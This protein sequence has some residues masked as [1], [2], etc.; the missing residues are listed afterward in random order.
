MKD[1]LVNNNSGKSKW[2]SDVIGD[3]FKEW[4]FKKDN[5]NALGTDASLVYIEAPTGSG[6]TYFILKKLL[7]YAIEKG[8]SIL[9]LSNRNILLKQIREEV[10]S[11]LHKKN[12]ENE[13]DDLLENGIFMYSTGPS[14][15]TVINYQS[16][17]GKVKAGYIPPEFLIEHYYVI[18]DEVHFFLEDSLFN[19]YIF[20]CFDLLMKT[21]HAS[22][23]VFISATIE[24]TMEVIN[25]DILEAYIP[26]RNNI[27]HLTS[28]KSIFYYKINPSIAK[29]KPYYFIEDE[30]II[31]AI[32]Q[33]R[34]DDKWLIFVSSKKHGIKLEAKITSVI[35]ELISDT[36]KQLRVHRTKLRQLHNEERA[37]K[38]EQI[39][40]LESEL[41]RL[42]KSTVEFIC[43]EDKGNLTT[44][45]IEYNSRFSRKVLIAT[46]VLD[47]GVNIKDSEVKHIVLP[48]SHRV[49]FIQMLGRKRLKD[50]E[51]VKLYIQYFKESVIASRNEKYRKMYAVCSKVDDIC[52]SLDFLHHPDYEIPR[53]IKREIYHDENARMTKMIQM[54]WNEEKPIQNL[55]YIDNARNLKFN[56]FA[57]SQLVNMKNFY[58]NL[59]INYKSIGEQTISNL[60]LDWLGPQLISQPQSLQEYLYGSLDEFIKKN[61]YKPIPLE[62]QD[63]FYNNY[64]RIFNIWLQHQY[65]TAPEKSEKWFKI[66]KGKD[67][68]KA[69]I[70]KSLKI[71]EKPYKLI[72]QNACWMLVDINE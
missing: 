21:Y 24:E 30:E 61:L 17:I 47:N 63:I 2:I 38:R 15:I 44:K 40:N 67:R 62:D 12:N 70:C 13:N 16:F 55:F 14:N 58:N 27:D 26:R 57:F 5:K 3:E 51:T 69:T 37:K 39:K 19:P 66:K 11:D 50:G 28:K 9:F 72:K 33:N 25:K 18:F 68:H 46:K 52:S 71:A 23:K 6:K 43:S 49:E 10:S 1:N 20:K 7:P 64:I 42:K 59:L 31:E 35:N 29:Y 65:V 45:N 8:R 48:F 36:E 60:L 53:A 41:D 4:K 32:K 22:V 56:I 34:L 54:L